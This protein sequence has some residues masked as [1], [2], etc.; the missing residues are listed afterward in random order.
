MGNSLLEESDCNSYHLDARPKVSSFYYSHI[1]TAPI[2]YHILL[3]DC[4]VQRIA[5]WLVGTKKK[6]GKNSCMR[7]IFNTQ[8]IPMSRFLS[9][10]A[11]V[12]YAQNSMNFSI[13]LSSITWQTHDH[14]I[15]SYVIHTNMFIH[16]AYALV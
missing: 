4:L 12:N 2:T 9:Q 13:L 10:W 1:Y 7:E 8:S 14:Y 5:T 16:C 3:G 11:L 6:H 15:N